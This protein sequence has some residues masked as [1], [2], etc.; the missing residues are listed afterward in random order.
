MVSLSGDPQM[1]TY[2]YQ[3]PR[4]GVLGVN[5]AMNPRCK[6]CLLPVMTVE[7][8]VWLRKPMGVSHTTC[9]DGRDDVIPV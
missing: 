2:G 6:L 8:R 7:E 1:N 5:S 9:A 3:K 4:K